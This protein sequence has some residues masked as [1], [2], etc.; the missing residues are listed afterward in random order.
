[1]KQLAIATVLTIAGVSMAP[2]A[3]PQKIDTRTVQVAVQEAP[4]PVFTDPG[5]PVCQCAACDCC[6][7]CPSS[8]AKVKSK[9]IVAP[10]RGIVG[11]RLECRGNHCARVPI[12]GDTGGMKTKSVTKVMS[13]DMG[14][15]MGRRRI[16][17]RRIFG[18]R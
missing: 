4:L 7:A 5:L 18:R 14:H 10:L 15:D 11:Y 13:H 12:Y 8:R 2:P 16:F 3:Q 1:M 17:G 6:A 9:S